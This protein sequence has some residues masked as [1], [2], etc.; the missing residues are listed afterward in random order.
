MP[1]DKNKLPELLSPA[2]SMRA[3]EAAIDA[4]ADAVYFGASSFNARIGAENFDEKE[5]ADAF[6][7]CHS[8]GVKAYL[9]LNTLALDREMADYLKQ[10]S[11]HGGWE[12]MRL[13]LQ[14]LEVRRR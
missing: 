3:L 8:Y 1:S 10:Q 2:G 13:S 12:R 11:R 9:T 6:Y 7:K 5:L 14:I 4:G